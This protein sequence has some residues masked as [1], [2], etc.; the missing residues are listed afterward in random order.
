MNFRRVRTVQH[1]QRDPDG[2]RVLLER[3]WAHNYHRRRQGDVRRQVAFSA[4]LR[5]GRLT[6][7]IKLL[8]LVS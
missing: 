8:P 1:A 3:R 7:K 5:L 4:R 2:R 6:D